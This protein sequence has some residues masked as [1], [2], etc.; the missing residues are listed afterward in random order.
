MAHDA[1]VIDWQILQELIRLAAQPPVRWMK[2]ALDGRLIA[3]LK[4]AGTR[5]DPE[6]PMSG[7]SPRKS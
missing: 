6:A 3:G 4:P 5:L 1:H 2:P 7:A